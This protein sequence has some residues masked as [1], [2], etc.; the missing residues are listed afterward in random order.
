MTADRRALTRPLACAA[1]LSALMAITA[2]SA[3][4]DTL[5]AIAGVLLLAV[6]LLPITWRD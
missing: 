4:Y 6:G 3:G 2:K 5:A 1:V